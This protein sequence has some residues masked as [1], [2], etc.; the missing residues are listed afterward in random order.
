MNHKTNMYHSYLTIK[1]YPGPITVRDRSHWFHQE[2]ICLFW[3]SMMIMPLEWL[4]TR[5]FF[6][7]WFH[8][9]CTSVVCNG[10]RTR[11]HCRCEGTELKNIP[12]V[13]T[14][15]LRGTTI[16][17]KGMLRVMP[18]KNISSNDAGPPT[19]IH[20]LLFLFLYCTACTVLLCIYSEGRKVHTLL[21]RSKTVF[22]FFKEY[23]TD[24]NGSEILRSNANK[25]LLCFNANLLD[26]DALGVGGACKLDQITLEAG[27]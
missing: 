22:H 5:M 17:W 23:K 11:P 4:H 1:I 24:P 26:N 25:Q 13:N 16:I 12:K 3:K 8:Y 7:M 9:V 15:S 18:K 6:V 2:F 19:T 27:N 10:F 20:T 21:I 14:V